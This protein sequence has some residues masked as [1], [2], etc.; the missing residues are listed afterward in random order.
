MAGLAAR[1]PVAQIRRGAVRLH[2]LRPLKLEEVLVRVRARV[3]ARVRVR[4]RVR[5]RVRVRMRVVAGLTK[6][7]EACAIRRL[8]EYCDQPIASSPMPG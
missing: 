5:N 1:F 8:S 3:R 2:A 7:G 6:L 4:V